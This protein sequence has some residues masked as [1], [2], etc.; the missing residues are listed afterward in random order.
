MFKILIILQQVSAITSHWPFQVIAEP[1]VDSG[2]L[3][4]GEMAT[5]RALV[6]TLS[7]LFF[8]NFKIKIFHHFLLLHNKWR[9]VSDTV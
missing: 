6:K 5:F 8:L 4:S 2:H 3:S 1:D 9:S 7:L